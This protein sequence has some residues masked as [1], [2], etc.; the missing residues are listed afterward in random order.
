MRIIN[1]VEQIMD[2]T[3]SQI[4][5]FPVHEEQLSQDVVTEAENTFKAII[6]EVKGIDTDSELMES[7]VEDG[8]Y[9]DDNGWEL[10]IVWS[11]T[12]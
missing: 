4:L 11:E 5:S 12:N 1:V 3:I 7:F 9:N 10:S 2:G 6:N 8:Y